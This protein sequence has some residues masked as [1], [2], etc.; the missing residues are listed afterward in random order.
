M[1]F[2]VIDELHGRSFLKDESK[3]IENQLP[4]EEAGF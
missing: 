3:E 2:F 1:S 4:Y